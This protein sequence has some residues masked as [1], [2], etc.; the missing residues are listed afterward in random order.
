MHTTSPK[1]PSH[2]LA[3]RQ[4]D[5]AMG[6]PRQEVARA[7]R[8]IRTRNW[9]QPTCVL[10]IFVEACCRPS[11]ASAMP[12]TKDGAGE[13][14][15]ANERLFMEIAQLRFTL[16]RKDVPAPT[17]LKAKLMGHIKDRGA[18]RSERESE[19]ERERAA[20]EQ[21]ASVCVRRAVCERS[22]ARQR[23]RVRAH[24][25]VRGALRCS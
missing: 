6:S 2:M 14:A 23:S 20:C 12:E 10:F 5:A 8:E 25:G 1:W 18:Q 7:P 4:R 19:S 15:A 3:L 9:V 13:G 22:G 21:P 24:S 17:E 11:G 16:A